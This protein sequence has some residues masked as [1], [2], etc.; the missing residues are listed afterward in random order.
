MSNLNG[1][2]PEILFTKAEQAIAHGR[3]SPGSFK[4]ALFLGE[5]MGIVIFQK[6]QQ[7]S[8]H[9]LENLYISWNLVFCI[10]HVPGT[11]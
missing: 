11:P 4:C 9:F 7:K 2:F 10:N 8:I 3:F 6:M 1:N 5:F